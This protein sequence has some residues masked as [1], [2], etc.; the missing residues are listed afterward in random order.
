MCVRAEWTR[1]TLELGPTVDGQATY[2]FPADASRILTLKVGGYPLAPGDAGMV[3][4]LILDRAYLRAYGIWYLEHEADGDEVV[5]IYPTPG[6]T[7][8]GQALSA[9]CIVVP[10]DLELE[11]E[12][13]VPADFQSGIRDYAAALIYGYTEDTFDLR[14]MH[15]GEFER[16]TNRLRALRMSRRG[17]GGVRMR[18]EGWTA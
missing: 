16:Q 18:V 14:Q 3:D 4:D 11:D 5:R 15:Y 12:P 7:A 2:A 9:Y 10:E 1:A 8:A 13:K 6:P 17:R